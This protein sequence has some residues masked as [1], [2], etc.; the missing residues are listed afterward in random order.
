MKRMLDFDQFLVFD[1][2]MGTMLQ[3]C[4]LQTGELAERSNLEQA[5]TVAEIHRAYIAAGSQ[6]VTTN[7]FSANRFKLARAGLDQA[8]VIRAAVET[9][10]QAAKDGL[11]ALDIGPLGQLMEPYGTLSFDEAYAAFAEQIRIGAE[12]GADLILIETMSDLYEA[13]AAVLAARENS[14]LP[15]FCTMTFQENGRTLTG[16]DP[17]TVVNVLQ[18]L[19]VAALGINC[20]LG[21]REILPVLEEIVKF[22]Q[23]P[24]IAQPN[25]GLPQLVEEEA[26]Y[27]ITPADFAAY[28]REMAAVG[29]RI[30]GGCCGTT[31]AHIKALKDALADT[32]P[33][34]V[35]AP[36]LKAASSGRTT[37]ILGGEVRIVGGRINPGTGGQ[38]ANTLL[39]ADLDFLVQQALNQQDEGADILDVNVGMPGIDEKDMM[40]EALKEIQGVVRLP[41]IISSADPE[42]IEAAARIYNGRPIINLEGT[43]SDT[44]AAIVPIARKYG[45]L[46]AVSAVDKAAAHGLAEEDILACSAVDWL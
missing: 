23:I 37:V 14:A 8:A 30:L 35:K 4:G 43:G 28:G 45:C 29:A 26:L 3:S 44:L 9:A 1:G 16:A 5:E 12:A 39:C 40:V 34:P 41:L 17:L 7:T 15:V 38:L 20:S 36:R 18:S 13:K 33:A 42:V 2:A 25:A 6:V 32:K 11:V 46:A 19:G 22:A 27:R 21:P 31:P 10:R 24:V